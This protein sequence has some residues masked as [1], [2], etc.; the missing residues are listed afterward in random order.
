MAQVGMFCILGL[1]V[2]QVR[3]LRGMSLKSPLYPRKTN[4]SPVFPDTY[5]IY[6]ADSSR[7]SIAGLNE[8]NIAYVAKAIVEVVGDSM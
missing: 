1:N 5:H 3:T 4:H 7:I 2:S 6:M 8:S